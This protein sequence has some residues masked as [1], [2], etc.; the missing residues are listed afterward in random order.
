MKKM[1]LGVLILTIFAAISAQA[2][3]S[4]DAVIS[5]DQP[6]GDFSDCAKSG[7]GIAGDVFYSLPSLPN[8]GLGGR[9]AWNRFSLD[10]SV[11]G[12]EGGNESIIEILPSIR[13]SIT[14]TGSQFGFFGQIGIGLYLWSY[15]EETTFG[16]FEDDGND[17]GFYFGGGA[18]GKFTD[19]MSFIFM[20]LFHII[21]TENESTTY[22]SLNFGITL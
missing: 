22:F 21:N 5:Y 16:D 15:T 17:F 10:D 9:L 13:Y 14:P 20:P 6:T 11:P 1:F 2:Q 19:K 3:I 7:F 12:I 8:L 4:Y 18:T